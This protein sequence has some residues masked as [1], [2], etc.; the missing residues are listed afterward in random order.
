MT[1]QDLRL[2]RF[3]NR[4]TKREMARRLDCAESWINLLELGHYHAPAREKW[5][6]LYEKALDELVAERKAVKSDS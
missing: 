4:I 3:A 6:G 5:A 1:W 2:R